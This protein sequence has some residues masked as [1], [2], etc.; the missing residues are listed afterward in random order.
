M[1][2]QLQLFENVKQEVFLNYDDATGISEYL[3][4]LIDHKRNGGIQR[5]QSEVIDSYSRK[6][7][8]K[9][10]LKLI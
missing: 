8:T 6:S 1:E 2:M 9:K 7:L 4:T 10:I 3:T 5:N